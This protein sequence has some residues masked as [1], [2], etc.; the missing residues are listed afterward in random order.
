MPRKFVGHLNMETKS[1]DIVKH[2]CSKKNCAQKYQLSSVHAACEPIIWSK[3][4]K[5]YDYFIIEEGMCE[6]LVGSQ[7]PVAKELAEYMVIKTIGHKYVR[8]EAGTI[9]TI[10]KF[11]EGISMKQQFSIGSCR[12]NLYFPENKLANECDK[13]DHKG[14]DIDYEIRRQTFI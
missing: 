6:L 10:Q 14:R 3:Y 13:H 2:L 9:Y 12:I 7:L 1:A 11:F 8:K 4:S 5:K